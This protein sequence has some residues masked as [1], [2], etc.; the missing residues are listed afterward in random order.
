MRL[1]GNSA[2]DI[3]IL[4]YFFSESAIFFGNKQT[5]LIIFVELTKIETLMANWI[6]IRVWS[7]IVDKFSTETLAEM[8]EKKNL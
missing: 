3:G 8:I 5:A 1:V 6:R 4:P 7:S 2:S